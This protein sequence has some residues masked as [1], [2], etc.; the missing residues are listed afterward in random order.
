MNISLEI[1]NKIFDFSK[2]CA[3]ELRCGNCLSGSNIHSTH[4]GIESIA[5]IEA[6]I[7]NEIPN[8]IE[9]ACSSTIF[10]SNIKKGFQRVA[11]VVFAKHIGFYTINFLRFDWNLSITFS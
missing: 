2:N 8:K 9:E 5:N 10:K 6:K 3:Y 4:F 7:W 11:L 1:M